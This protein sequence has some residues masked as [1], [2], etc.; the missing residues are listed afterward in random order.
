MIIVYSSKDVSEIPKNSLFG[1]FSCTI[2][3][4]LQYCSSI[5]NTSEFFC[6]LFLYLVQRLKL[7]INILRRFKDLKITG[8]IRVDLATSQ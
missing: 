3:D 7:R 8:A 4:S 5:G 2:L 1:E 6:L